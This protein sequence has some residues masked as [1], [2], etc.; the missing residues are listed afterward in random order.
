MKTS[1]PLG[2]AGGWEDNPLILYPI[3]LGA[4]V[5]D[6]SFRHYTG[7]MIPVFLNP[8]RSEA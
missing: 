7:N 4:G 1:F 6:F 8:E 2:W 5:N 3:P